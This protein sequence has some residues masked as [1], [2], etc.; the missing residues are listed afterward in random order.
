MDFFSAKHFWVP[1]DC[2]VLLVFIHAFKS[3]ADIVYDIV[4][5]VIMQAMPDKCN[6]SYYALT[7]GL[8]CISVY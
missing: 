4:I 6:M 3:V 1:V 7:V 8:Y 2:C 5:V